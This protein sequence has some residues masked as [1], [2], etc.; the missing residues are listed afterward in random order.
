MESRREDPAVSM[1]TLP[2]V[3]SPPKDTIDAPCNG[4]DDPPAGSRSR[5]QSRG[6]FADRHQ[7]YLAKPP[8]RVRASLRSGRMTP[9]RLLA[10][11]FCVALLAAPLASC[12][13]IRMGSGSGRLTSVEHGST[14]G[15]QF[16]TRVYAGTDPNVVDFYLTDLPESVW[17]VGGDVSN[18][19]GT[20]LHVHLFLQPKA[21]RTPIARTAN[22][23]TV[24][25]LVLSEGRVGVYGGA[26]FLTLGDDVGEPSLDARLAGAS[27]RLVHQS[28]GFADSLGPCVLDTSFDAAAEPQVAESLARAMSSLIASSRPPAEP[29]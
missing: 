4:T 7:G 26:G 1:I 27:L 25:W 9:A 22:T 16:T 17:T 19:S 24:R 3:D 18:L 5:P 12:G 11:T 15:A 23:A 21:G 10:A 29:R 14:L 20:I 2:A 8:G 6:D 13:S 28:P